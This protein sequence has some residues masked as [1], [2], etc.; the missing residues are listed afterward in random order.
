M[1]Q[2]RWLELVSDYDYEFHYHPNKAN[3]VADALSQKSM[4]FAISVEK[5]S[6][7]LQADLCSLGIEVIIGKL[8]AL[9]IQPTIMEAIN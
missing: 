8:L 1:R 4:A 7:P 5:M 3:K 2:H 6:R 9:T